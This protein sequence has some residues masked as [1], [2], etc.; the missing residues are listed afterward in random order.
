MTP[1]A[2]AL[3]LLQ[4]TL[5][6]G[7][8]AL[9]D[10]FSVPSAPGVPAPVQGVVVSADG[11]PLAVIGLTP[12]TVAADA[13]ALLEFLA[14]KARAQRAPYLVALNLRDAALWQT[15][16]KGIPVL[17]SEPL[18]RYPTLFDLTATLRA[19]SP[20]P[21]PLRL[22]VQ[23]RAEEILRDLTT[24]HRDGRLDLVIPDAT[25]FVQR[26]IRAVE[27]LKPHLKE[28]LRFELRHKVQFARELE[29]WAIEQGIPADLHSDDFLEAI[30]RQAI[31]R[32]LGKVIFYQSL[33][34]SVRS[35]PELNLTG[36]DSSFVMP[37]LRAAF[38]E[39]LKV[40]YH[41]VF[42]EVLIDRLPYPQA[43]ATELAALVDDLNTRDFAGLPQDV[44]GQVFEQLIP[45]EE[46]HGLGQF[47]TPEPLADLICAFCV[48]RPDDLVLDPTAGTGTFLIRAYDRL[49]WMG[50]QQHTKLLSQL[51][52][53]DIAPFP[54][55]LAT[56]NLFRQRVDEH[57]NFPRILCQD[58]FRLRPGQVCR[59]P[60]LKADSPPLPPQSWGGPRG[61]GE[62]P[63]VGASPP[64]P[65]P[66]QGYSPAKPGEG[67]VGVEAIDEPVPTFDAVVG[68]LPYIGNSQIERQEAGY[69]E[70]IRRV[71]AEDWFLD[72]PELFTIADRPLRA[73]YERQRQAGNDPSAGSGHR[74]AAFIPHARP[75]ISTYADLYVYLFF[76]AARFLK[77]SGRLGIVTSNAWLDVGY[78]H[79]LQ[80]FFLGCFKIVAVLESRCRTLVRGRGGEH[81][82]C[83][84]GA[85]RRRGRA[86]RPRG[87]VR[88]GQ[89]QTGRPDPRRPAPGGPGPLATAERPGTTDRI[90]PSPQPS[91]HGGEGVTPL[92]LSGRGAG[93]EGKGRQRF[94]HPYRAPGRAAGAGR[95]RRPDRQMGAIPPR[96]RRLL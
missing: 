75:A 79:A 51:W 1:E 42:A 90:C 84:P 82:G 30:T 81:R 62:G 61:G 83:H 14:L 72:A 67:R 17:A 18:R 28:A 16:R 31:Y 4:A 89:A 33:R 54:A 86:R 65:S 91:P 2:E 21:V 44:V 71:V 69:L 27:V 52:G 80:R 74:L 45:R 70:T 66:Y 38:A 11:S 88:S 96:P 59:F 10:T 40:D 76:H 49:Y 20:L 55:E 95:S 68:N 48:R 93:G 34:R 29:R 94:A 50:A 78:G 12:P 56:I 7:P 15:P 36:V 35:L 19:P 41:A 53:V 92:S 43:A 6:A 60:P 24:L 73:D 63:G 77:P 32:L 47:F 64:Q 23:R 5:P 26:L 8:L 58:F 37:R 25:F 85:V 3:A 9:A 87:Q 22:A 46:R 57:G 39:A 13:P